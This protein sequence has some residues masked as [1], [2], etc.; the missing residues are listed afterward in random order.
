M[1]RFWRVS[2]RGY[3]PF[4][5]LAALLFLS[6][7]SVF[8]QAQT[9]EILGSVTDSSGAAVPGAKVTITDV[10]TSIARQV[11]TDDQGR[12]DASSLNIGNYQVQTEMQGF[13]LQVQKGLVLAVGQRVVAD[14]K[15][16][17][18]TVAE[19]VTVSSTVATAVNTTTSEVGGLVNQSQ[20]QGLPL[21]GRNYE[22]LFS[23]VPGVQ[24]VQGAGS[25]S[26][27]FGSN[28][29]FSVAG[30]RV[31]GESVLLDGV[32]IRSMWGQGAGLQVLGTSLG[33]E[34]IAEFQTMTSSFNAQYA[35]LSVMNE[36][37]RSG[38]ND[39]H[40][41]AYG[42]FRNSNLN[43]RNFFDPATGPPPTHYDQFGG[44]VGGPIKKN[45][46]FFF[47]N[48]E[49][50]RATLTDYNGLYLPDANTR[51][52]YL[53]CSLAP[54]VTCIS[55][56]AHVGVNPA[57]APYLALYPVPPAGAVEVA[58]AGV[59]SITETSSTPQH[60]N[61][62]TA[63][64][65]HQ[66][67]QKDNI[68]FRYVIDEGGQNNPW[69]GGGN[70]G[71][72][73]NVDPVPF[74]ESTP[75]RDQ[76]F[77]VQERHIYSGSLINVATASFV[78]THYED[79]N[80][81]T[82]PG[83][84]VANPLMTFI[85]GRVLGSI[86]ISNVASLTGTSSYTPAGYTQN[87][88][89]VQDEV[90]WI[91]G[92][93]ALKIGASLNRIY[94]NCEQNSYAGLGY[95]FG[96]AGGGAN[97]HSGLEGFLEDKPTLVQ[98]P[99]PGQTDAERN[100][101]Q[102]DANV[103]FQDDWK[104]TRKLT[105][106]L[107]IRYDFT[108][109]PTEAHDQI[110]R[111]TDALAGTGFSRESHVFENNPSLKNI[112]PRIGLA[113]DVFGDHKTSVRSGFGMFD[114][115]MYPRAYIPGMSLAF[116]YEVDSQAYPTFPNPLAGGFGTGTFPIR[117]ISQAP[118]N[119]CC[120]PYMMEY[121]LTVERQLPKGLALSL[122]YVGSGS[123]HLPVDS[124][125]NTVIPTTI[126]PNGLQYRA[127]PN[128]PFP[129]PHF[130]EIAQMPTVGNS[131][132]NSM[133]LNVKRNVGIIQLQSAFTWSRCLDIRSSEFGGVAVGNDSTAW[134]YPTPVPKFYNY[135]PCAFNVG[136]NWT[137]NA[138]I[139]LPF[140][141]NW[142]KEGWQLSLIASARDGSPLTAAIN[143]ANYD[144]SNWGGSSGHTVTAWAQERPN[145][146]PNPAGPLMTRNV[147]EWFNYNDFTL[148]QPGYM[149]TES[150]GIIPGPG[151]FDMD[152][153]VIKE[154]SLRKFGE[155]TAVQLRGD[156]FNV[157]NHTNLSL[158]SGIIYQS[159][160]PTAAG[161]KISSTVGTSRQMQISAKLVF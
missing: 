102:T 114:D 91:R 16:E 131:H 119:Q 143:Q 144:I 83:S 24:P 159:A 118:W 138:I 12:Y 35:G 29:K 123:V 125:Y 57:V 157:F 33:V 85:P 59:E 92:G 18:G 62:V 158:P 37:T 137:S 82:G 120:I 81:F 133:V 90:D 26:A 104:A 94:C 117:A 64:I 89:S 116:P 147:N 95:T 109:N 5:V 11:T 21:N 126:L 112:Q 9:G 132:Y 61:F 140:H 63:K 44:A 13:A 107:G 72:P 6:S 79:T 31:A 103:Y 10:D 99:I 76:Y 32:S 142:L 50:L 141:G 96:V 14:F 51:N 60:E 27:N 38:T 8:G 93:H 22:Q 154:I 54:D 56:L 100:T 77:T 139:R 152:T 153:S 105:I 161:A 23:L 145:L 39:L 101:A 80:T 65:D 127:S 124:E 97:P 121:N 146:S 40:G 149:G 43:T 2:C 122:A 75:E 88:P 135:G 73:G 19:S 106:N 17:V 20:M 15:L 115:I 86:T 155:S 68:A 41:S 98:G 69:A 47:V 78:R 136:R 111:I 71:T 84:A 45:K 3:F 129:N 30:A 34:G 52:G 108:S 128:G 49:G 130:S 28:V 67:S 70:V 87:V 151:Y 48:Y 4:L 66:L 74:S 113:W 36:V 160:T 46:T 25:T 1:G 53:P 55:G 7:R 58:N 110:Y 134:L 42:F 156:V 148:P 150:R